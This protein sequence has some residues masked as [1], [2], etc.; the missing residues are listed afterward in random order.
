MSSEG[1]WTQQNLSSAS[2]GFDHLFSNDLVKARETFSN[3]DS[4]F[5]ALGLGVC[6]FLEAALGME[7]GLMAEASRCLALSEAGAKKQLKSSKSVKPNTQ[8]PPGTEWELLLADAVILLGLTHALS[9][10]Y[11]GYMQC[12]YAMNSAHTKFSKLFKTVYPHGLSELPTPATSVAPSRAPS[13]ISDTSSSTSTTTTKQSTGRSFFRWGSSAPV[14]PTAVPSL[15]MVSDGSV[16]ELI[17][18]GTAF[19]YGLFN[20]VFSLLPAKIRGVVGFLGFNHDRKLALQALAVSAARNDVHA[21]FAGLSLMTYHGVVLLLSGYQADEQHIL[22]QYRAVVDKV[23]SRYPD[24]SLWILNHAK[25]LRMSY[26]TEGAINVLQDGLRPDRPKS[27]AQADGLLVFELAWTLLS[28]RRYQEAADTFI[29]MTEINSWSHATYYFIAAGCHISLKN[30]EEAQKL[31]DAIPDLIDKRKIGGKDL[32]TEVFIKKKLA[33]YQEKQKRWTGSDANFA[34]CIRVSPAEELAIFWNTH[35]R[36]KKDVAEAHIADLC[37]FSPTPTIASPYI[38]V[39]DT[40]H[41]APA[42]ADLDTTDEIAVR[43]LLLGITHRTA[44]A[45]ETA[46]AFLVDA[47]RRQPTIK[48][49]TWVGGVALFELAVLE[50]KETEE[51]TERGTEPMPPKEAKEEWMKV[52]KSAEETLDKALALATQQVDLSSRLDSRIAMLR[53]EV[54]SKK[55]LVAGYA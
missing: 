48:T 20:L 41:P 45:F 47:H 46:R 25:I 39:E 50:L 1:D 37:S 32:P 22:K 6:A 3:S 33:F 52:L 8:F 30:Y 40:P 38:T 51:R 12:L 10:S 11:M 9:E 53:D 23:S 55:E 17:M 4:P 29:K 34:Q 31:L 18:S 24:G 19:G 44:G 42:R 43:A 16:D 21:V 49:S 15:S 28:Q 27:F 13:V 14:A 35:A 7:T 36:I 26:D 5:H 54:L 2:E